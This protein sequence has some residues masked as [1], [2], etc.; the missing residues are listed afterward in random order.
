[1]HNSSP[2][3]RGIWA[4]IATVFRQN[5]VPCLVINALV[6]TL[7]A[8]YYLYPPVAGMWQAVGDFK[9]RWS[10]FFSFCSTVLSAALLPFAVQWAMGTLPAEDRARRLG[11]MILFWG[12]RGMEID[13]LYHVQARLFGQGNDARTLICKVL[14]DQFV[15]ST[16]WAVPTYVVALRWIDLGGSWARARTSMDRHFWTHTVITVLF[17]NWLV[18]IPTVVLVYSLPA[19]LQFPLFSVVMCF[20]ILI[21]TLLARGPVHQAAP[22]AADIGEI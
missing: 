21:V 19:P 20:F 16:F 9:T 14:V 10:F 13:L 5:R 8:S 7:V 17:T 1:M 3:Q 12:Y 4:S 15:Y 6:I 2:S 11:L 22:V 18:W